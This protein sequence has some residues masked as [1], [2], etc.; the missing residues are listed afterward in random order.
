MITLPRQLTED[1]LISSLRQEGSWIWAV[2]S[3]GSTAEL[4]CRNLSWIEPGGLTPLA[5]IA[6]NRRW[7]MINLSDELH[8]YFQ[9]MGLTGIFGLNDRYQF[10]SR[11]PAGRFITA[12]WV[13]EDRQIEPVIN[14]VKQLLSRSSLAS[15]IQWA[16]SWSINELLGNVL[17]HAK[18]RSGGVVFAQTWS[19]NCT[20]SIAVCDAG[21]GILGSVQDRKEC[22]DVE[23]LQLAFDQGWTSK[24]GGDGKGNGLYLLSQIVSS[25]Q[26]HRLTVIS[27]K[28]V[29]ILRE[30]GKREYIHLPFSWPG[31][32]NCLTLDFNVPIEMA[33]ILG[34][35]DYLDDDSWSVFSD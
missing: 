3:D 15:G 8:H 23:A 14:D 10:Q 6:E 16:T 4:D 35:E 24:P 29:M 32:S 1:D 28:A 11:D 2:M 13:K 20:G 21:I 25:G 22:S 12:S 27:G 31:T 5:C 7:R 30:G 17:I 33:S 26:G 18:A 9:R 19:S 34:H